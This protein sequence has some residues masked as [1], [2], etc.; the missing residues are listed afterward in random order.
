[1]LATAVLMPAKD[2][3]LSRI[4]RLCFRTSRICLPSS[5]TELVACTTCSLPLT[6]SDM[7]NFTSLL[8]FV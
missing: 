1:M 2:S 6:S 5:R 7:L 8:I 3:M 4:V